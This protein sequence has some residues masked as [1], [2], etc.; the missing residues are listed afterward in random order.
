VFTSLRN[1]FAIAP[2][3]RHARHCKRLVVRF[4]DFLISD[5]CIW[6]NALSLQ[7]FSR[8]ASSPGI[9]GMGAP[10]L[11]WRPTPKSSSWLATSTLRPK[12][13]ASNAC[14]RDI[15]CESL[16][17]ILKAVTGTWSLPLPW[18]SQEMAGPVNGIRRIAKHRFHGEKARRARLLV[19]PIYQTDALQAAS[20]SGCMCPS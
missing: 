14:R 2:T 3:L 18:C 16:A 19:V 20:A 13:G 10:Y 8:G 15:P 12:R 11:K 17:T 1:D 6:Q 7:H 9:G 4:L 5:F